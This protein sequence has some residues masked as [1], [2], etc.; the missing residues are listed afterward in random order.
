[1]IKLAQIP[2]IEIKNI[3]FYQTVLNQSNGISI[4]SRKY[5][6]QIID[7]IKKQKNLTSPR[8]FGILD[9][10]KRGDFN[11]HPKN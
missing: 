8:Q 11:Y 7:S 1:M 6:Q 10:I 2:S 4:S 3:D 9:R 5:F